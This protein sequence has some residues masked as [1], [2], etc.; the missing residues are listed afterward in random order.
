[1]S[2]LYGRSYDV[3]NASCKLKYA[4]LKHY[5][6]DKRKTTWDELATCPEI[7]EL[8]L[9]SSAIDIIS[10]QPIRVVGSPLVLYE[11]SLLPKTEND[12]PT[13]FF[14]RKKTIE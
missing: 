8:Y 11:K 5:K 6:K 12:E 2:R 10:N 13:I 14:Q 4:N 7:V 9:P 1:M 3:Y